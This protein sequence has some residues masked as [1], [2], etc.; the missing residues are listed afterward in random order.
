MLENQNDNGGYK[1]VQPGK[2]TGA[3]EDV[4]YFF[5]DGEWYKIGAA[6]VDYP[7]DVTDGR[8]KPVANGEWR[9]GPPPQN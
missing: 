1:Q 9:P 2:S 8:F 6:T 5:H 7:K 4:D 3:T